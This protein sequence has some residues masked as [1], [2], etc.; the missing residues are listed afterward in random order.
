[1]P[2]S[3]RSSTRRRSRPRVRALAAGL[4]LLTACT[5]TP[6]VEVLNPGSEPPRTS[7]PRTASGLPGSNVPSIAPP[8][9]K[10]RLEPNATVIVVID[11]D[12]V[13][14]RLSGGDR[15]RVRLIGIDTPETKRPDTPVECFGKEAAS[16]LASLLPKGTEV[17]IE[18]DV[19]LR[20]RF[21]RLLGYLYRADDGLFVNFEMVRTG[22]AV[23]LTF[24]PNVTYADEFREASA[25][26]RDSGT[27]LWSRCASGHE[28]VSSATTKATTAASTEA[29]TG[30][31]ESASAS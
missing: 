11:G 15:E 31:G 28:P 20:D 10:G 6:T 12:T 18:R 21:G 30:V 26:A 2:V 13:D 8:Q 25:A 27:G 19:E 5:A 16:A 3:D 29:S 14:L 4:V 9:Q 7:A 23:A 1:M 17:T 24:P 22:F